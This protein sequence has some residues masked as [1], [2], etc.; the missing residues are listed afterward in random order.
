M[1]LS[2]SNTNNKGLGRL[3]IKQEKRLI[4]HVRPLKRNCKRL[5]IADLSDDCLSHV[6]RRLESKTDQSSFRLVCRHWLRIQ[7]N[8]H[9]SLWDIDNSNCSLCKSPKFS[10]EI[11][12]MILFKLLI[13]F[14]HLKYLNLSGLPKVTNYIASRSQFLGSKV[15]FL[16]LRYCDQYSDMELSLLLSSFPRLTS[17]VLSGS[18]INDKGLENLGKCCASLEKIEL[19][20]CQ[21]ITDKGLDVLAKCCASLKIVYLNGCQGITD[22]GLGVL[23]KCCASLENVELGFCKY[24]TDEG[25]EVLAKC[26]ASLEKVNLGNCQ[27]IT[28]KGLGVLAKSCASLKIVNLTGCQGITDK[29]LE[30]LAKCSASLENVELGYCQHITDKGIEFLAM[31]K[32]CAS[33]EIVDLT[34]CQGITDSGLSSLIKNCSKLHSLRISYC[35]NVTGTGFLGCPKTLTTVDATDMC[36]LTMEGVKAIA[37]GGGIQYLKLSGRAV[38]S[39][40]VITISKGCPLLKSLWLKSCHLVG[41]KGWTAI[42]LYCKNLEYLYVSDCPNLCD[43]SLQALQ[44]GCSKLFYLYIDC[45]SELD[46]ELFKQKRPNVHLQKKKK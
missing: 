20:S 26:C 19:G 6:Y 36:K 8:T 10:P 41:L 16:N 29:G 42:S 15:R 17:V 3:L 25:I 30:V 37:S 22:K 28:N 7:N 44:D 27:R 32:C 4:S 31:E 11:F 14:Q 45:W 34:C 24:I 12:S 46:F 21:G 40:V 39:Q 33:L 13:R 43:Q 35:K 5:S 18:F 9:E 2:T 23:A 1:S 38:N